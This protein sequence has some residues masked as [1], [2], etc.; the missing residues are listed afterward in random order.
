M[1]RLQLISRVRQI[2]R[3]LDDSVFLKLTII[4]FLNEGIERCQQVIPQ[5]AGMVALPTTATS[6][7][8][9]TIPI[10]LPSEHHHLL[11]IYGASRCFYQDERHYQ[12][13]N[14][15]NEFESKLGELK[16]AVEAGDIV[17]VDG[18]G[19]AIEITLPVDYVDDIYFVDT[20]DLADLDEGV[21]GVE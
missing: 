11:A 10:L 20:G 4:D 1:N 12:A 6:A 15:M 16:D 2:T 3:D 19:T 18:T 9:F 17:I 21:E 14:L 13:S 7:S 8:D 5:L